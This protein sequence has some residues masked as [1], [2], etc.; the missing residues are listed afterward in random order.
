MRPCG[1]T[2]NVIRTGMWPNRLRPKLMSDFPSRGHTSGPTSSVPASI[3]KRGPWD[4]RLEPDI[5]VLR[6]SLRVHEESMKPGPRD[7][8]ALGIE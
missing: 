3:F 8:E 5:R 1:S 6:V 2:H 7:D 4:P